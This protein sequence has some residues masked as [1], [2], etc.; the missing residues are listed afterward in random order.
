MTAAPQ[1]TNDDLAGAPPST[2][3]GVNPPELPLKHRETVMEFLVDM[4]TT[5]PDGTTSADIEAV[6]GHVTRTR[7]PETP[8]RA[9]ATP[10]APGEW[11]T[12]GLFQ[13]AD[14]EELDHVLASM[15]LCAWRRDTVTAL[16]PHTSD[17]AGAAS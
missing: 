2:A 8:A 11:R 14:A 6:S 16:T 5:V 7:R 1:T 9:V 15:P 3:G 17:P 4:V 12:L 10:L 13:A